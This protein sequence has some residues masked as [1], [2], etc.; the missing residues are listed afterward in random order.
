MSNM[1][2]CCFTN[3]RSDLADCL[4]RLSGEARLSSVEAQAGRNMFLEFLEFC[5]DCGIIPSYDKDM[6]DE[7][8][9]S[10]TE[11]PDEDDD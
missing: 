9:R 5:D 4:E 2:Y 6:L 1:S 11:K 7:L 8:F 3:T 10:L